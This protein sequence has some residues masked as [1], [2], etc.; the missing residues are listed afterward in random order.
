M[1][2]LRL[3]DP[4]GVLRGVQIVEAE[5]FARG[6][7]QHRSRSIHGIEKRLRVLAEVFHCL[8]NA[9]TYLE[10]QFTLETPHPVSRLVPTQPIPHEVPVELARRELLRGGT[11]ALH[12]GLDALEDRFRPG[13]VVMEAPLC[14][15]VRLP[16]VTLRV[17]EA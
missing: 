6:G 8:P 15:G 11:H 1:I 5:R 14:V 7:S 16:S 10:R 4:V 3:G 17:S 2:R 9:T 13:S 12:R